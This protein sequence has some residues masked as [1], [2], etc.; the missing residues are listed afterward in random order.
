MGGHECVVIFSMFRRWM[1]NMLFLII[2]SYFLLAFNVSISIFSTHQL[3]Y[4]KRCTCVNHVLN[5]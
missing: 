3:P 2:P 4:I 5:L 1:G